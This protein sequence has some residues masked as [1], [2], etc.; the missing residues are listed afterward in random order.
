[1]SELLH[2][3]YQNRRKLIMESKMTPYELLN[4]LYKDF[5]VVGF[6]KQVK[7]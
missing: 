2:Q 7:Y 1:M 3:T 6:E 5:P 4:K